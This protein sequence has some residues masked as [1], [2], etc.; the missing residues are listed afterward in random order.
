M[1]GRNRCNWRKLWGRTLA[2]K[3]N[4]PDAVQYLHGMA[5]DTTIKGDVGNIL[6][7]IANDFMSCT[8]IYK[9]LLQKILSNF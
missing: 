6:L 8:L 9:Y 2:S 4:K 3:F 7:E 5:T 1:H